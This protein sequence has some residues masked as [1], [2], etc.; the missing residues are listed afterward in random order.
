MLFP[1][2]GGGGA[3]M[4]MLATALQAL[5]QGQSPEAAVQRAVG[6]AALQLQLPG[7]QGLSLGAAQQLLDQLSSGAPLALMTE[8]EVGSLVGGQRGVAAAAGVG[9]GGVGGRRS[10]GDWELGREEVGQG[11]QLLQAV[12]GVLVEL[13]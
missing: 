1:A 7:M 4:L 12:E 2:T 3:T 6:L 5:A 10:S 8:C 13:W 9:V 11:Q